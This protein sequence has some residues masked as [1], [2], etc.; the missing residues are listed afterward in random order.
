[1]PRHASDAAAAY[2]LELFDPSDKVAVLAV[3]RRKAQDPPVLQRITPAGDVAG[4]RFQAWLRHLNANG[5]D[6]F[7]GMNPLTGEPRS[8]G[9]GRPRPHREKQDVLAIRRLQLDLDEAGEE[10]FA[11]VLEDAQTGVLPPPA[12]TLRSSRHNYQV[13]WNTT[14]DWTVEQAEDVMARLADHYRGDPSVADVARVMRLPGYRNKKTGRD[15]ALASWTPYGGALVTPESFPALPPRTTTV[16]ST[17]AAPPAPPSHRLL[18]SPSGGDTSPSGQ[19]WAWTR[20]RLAA[21]ADPDSLVA[22]LVERR[23]DKHNPLDYATRTVRNAAES[24]RLEG[25]LP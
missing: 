15:D 20:D 19:D 7:L 5:Y 24:L 9:R 1:M 11:R 13:L 6:L 23:Q 25:R 3:G 12:V 8:N 14:D 22:L 4:N 18:R 21:D 10:S 2:V 16:P 17:A